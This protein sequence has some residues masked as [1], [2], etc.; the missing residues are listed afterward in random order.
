MVDNH[1]WRN[2]EMRK[3]R[4]FAD[5]LRKLFV[6]MI[7]TDYILQKHDQR[8][9]KIKPLDGTPAGSHDH[10]TKGKLEA[11]VAEFFPDAFII[12]E[13]DEKSPIE[14]ARIL[15]RQD[16]LQ[17]SVDGL[18]GTGNRGMRLLSFGGT[19][20][21]RKGPDILFAAVFRPMEERIHGAG[22]FWAAKGEGAWVWCGGKDGHGEFERVLTAKRGS[23][24]RIKIMLEGSSKRFFYEPIVT[25]GRT[26]NTRPSCSSCV[27]GT[28]V[29]WGEASALITVRNAVWDNWPAWLMI[30]EAGGI[31]TGWCGEQLAPENCGD[32]FA[33]A[34]QDD[35]I[36]IAVVFEKWEEGEKRKGLKV[37]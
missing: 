25:I 2:G 10:S 37:E 20:A 34:N 29:A 17:V 28:T 9:D 26:F 31:V 3:M 24:E 32:M 6:S 16:E 30:Q 5:A 33:A 23:L 19:V 18:D 35:Y 11:L 14:I 4:E 22:F 13:E 7:D 21:L 36:E 8:D 1:K 27:A 12:S 15:A